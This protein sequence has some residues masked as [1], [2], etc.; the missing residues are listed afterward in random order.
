VGRP[1]DLGGTWRLDPVELGTRLRLTHSEV[2]RE[3]A[4]GF[5]AGWHVILDV[6]DRYFAGQSW[7]DIWAT[8][9]PLAEHYAGLEPVSPPPGGTAARP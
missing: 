8:Y 2:P 3:P 5:A 1:A 4:T 9:D 7:D 6:L